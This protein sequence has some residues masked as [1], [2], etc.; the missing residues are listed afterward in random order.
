MTDEQK[1]CP[2]GAPCNTEEGPYATNRMADLFHLDCIDPECGWSIIAPTVEQ[3]LV[4]WNRR[5]LDTDK[6][7]LW[8]VSF[9]KIR[10][11]IVADQ[12][13]PTGGVLGDRLLN[14]PHS[15]GAEFVVPNTLEGDA[16]GQVKLMHKVAVRHPMQSDEDFQREKDHADGW[17]KAIAH[18]EVASGQV[19][20]GG[21]PMTANDPRNPYGYPPIAQAWANGYNAALSRTQARPVPMTLDC[22][23]CNQ[24]HVDE[25]EWATRPHKTH[26]CQHCSHEWRP[27]PYATVGKPPAQKQ[28]GS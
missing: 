4:D 5:V 8:G 3:A 7:T 21:E 17:N 18:M 26:Q 28:A 11:L 27:F 23:K 14:V 22:P 15:K 20:G 19:S 13:R 1:P 6:G 2:C 10:E 25:G 16:S 24:R 12:A 9:D